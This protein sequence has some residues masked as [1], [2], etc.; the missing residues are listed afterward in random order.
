[1]C[2]DELGLV[3]EVKGDERAGRDA[4]L[5]KVL[6]VSACLRVRFRPC[7]ASR[8]RPDGFFVVL[9]LVYL[10]FEPVPEAGAVVFAYE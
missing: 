8:P 3:C 10:C 9:S 4:V 6:S 2:E 1:M 5:Q 7:I